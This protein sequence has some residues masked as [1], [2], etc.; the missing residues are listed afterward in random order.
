MITHQHTNLQFQYILQWNAVCTFHPP[1]PLWSCHSQ[2]SV[3]F[4]TNQPCQYADVDVCQMSA[5]EDCSCLHTTITDGG[6]CVEVLQAIWL[7]SAFQSR[8]HKVVNNCVPRR[9]EFLCSLVLGP[10]Q[11]SAAS[12]SMDR[13]G[14]HGTAYRLPAA[15]RSFKR[16]VPE[17]P[18]G[19]IVTAQRIWRRI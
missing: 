13:V 5:N 15:L 19:A 14:L 7:T 12:L 2:H 8:L 4:P 1:S 10:L 18:F 9:P 17:Q 11:A 6:V 3:C 16:Q